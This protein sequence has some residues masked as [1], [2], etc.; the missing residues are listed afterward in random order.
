MKAGKIERD[1]S[2]TAGFDGSNQFGVPFDRQRK[3]VRRK[4]QPRDIAM[5]ADS[6][7][8]EAHLAQNPLG[9]CDARQ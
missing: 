5:M 6:A 3:F 8:A 2:V 7:L 1:K 4:L 9:L